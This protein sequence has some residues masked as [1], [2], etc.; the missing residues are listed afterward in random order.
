ML[1]LKLGL[2][3]QSEAARIFGL[4]RQRIRQWC[5]AE[6]LDSDVARDAFLAGLIAHLKDAHNET[7]IHTAP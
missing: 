4:T 7:R 5:Q 1:M 3:T 2:I 6:S